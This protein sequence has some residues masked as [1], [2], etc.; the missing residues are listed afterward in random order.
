MTAFGTIIPKFIPMPWFDAGGRLAPAFPFGTGCWPRGI[1]IPVFDCWGII[2]GIPMG[3]KPMPVCGRWPPFV[4]A[5][6]AGLDEFPMAIPII[7]VVPI[8]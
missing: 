4:G 6:L 5:I 2:I 1:A 3:F 8:G 7:G